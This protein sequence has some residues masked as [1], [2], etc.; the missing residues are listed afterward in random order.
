[1][2]IYDNFTKVKNG[3]T[4]NEDSL[5]LIELNQGIIA[6]VADGVSKSDNSFLASK[7]ASET[8]LN[9]FESNNLKNFSG[10]LNLINKKI[11]ELNSLNFQSSATTLTILSISEDGNL[12][13]NHVGDCRIYIL[14]NNGLKT[15]T[16]DQTEKQLLI[17]NKILDRA[18]LARYKGNKLYSAL[19]SSFEIQEGFFDLINHDRVIICSDGIY[20]KFSK[21]EF[22]EISTKN[23]DFS[24]FKNELFKKLET[25]QFNDDASIVLLEYLTEPK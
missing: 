5:G 6:F 4:I 8:I 3:K 14:R 20:N 1:M 19:G 13:F 16:I 18:R 24:Q 17:K 9:W 25:I 11:L 23:L 7:T 2:F 12:M 15:L 22:V 21:K 10:L